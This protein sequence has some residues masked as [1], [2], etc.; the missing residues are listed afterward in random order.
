MNRNRKMNVKQTIDYFFKLEEFEK[1]QKGAETRGE[2][3]VL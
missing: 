1:K 2:T 3:S